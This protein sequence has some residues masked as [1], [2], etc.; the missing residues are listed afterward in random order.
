MSCKSSA[1]CVCLCAREENS[2]SF[3]ENCVNFRRNATKCV[4]LCAEKIGK[5][6]KSSV[7]VSAARE[8]RAVFSARE[9]R[10][11]RVDGK[12]NFSP[13]SSGY[14]STK[15]DRHDSCVRELCFADLVESSHAKVNNQ[16]RVLS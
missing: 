2:V 9:S 7:C 16:H 13:L 6:D 4:K 15:V 5:C 10:F 3:D 12:F 8:L 14:F 11:Q 1:A